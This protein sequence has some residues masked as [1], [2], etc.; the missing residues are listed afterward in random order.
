MAATVPMMTMV[1]RSTGMAVML[2]VE[3]KAMV[4]K[5]TADRVACQRC[6][7]S[8]PEIK[9]AIPKGLNKTTKMMVRSAAIS[10][11]T[12]LRWALSQA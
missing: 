10:I 8:M 1:K 4:A 3:M 7:I 9:A 2:G 5:M 12:S 11:G 6:L